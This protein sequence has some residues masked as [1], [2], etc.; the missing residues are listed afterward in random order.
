MRRSSS[1]INCLL[2]IDKPL[3]LSSHDVVGRVRRIL[4]ERRVGH[5]GTLDPAASGVLVIGVGQATRLLGMLTLDDKRYDA[6]IA[7]GCETA[8]DDAEGEVVREAEVPARLAEPAVAGA[9]VASLV[10][11]CEQ[12]PPA[13]SAISVDGRRAYDRARAGEEVVLPARHVVVHEATLVGVREGERLVWD[14]S[15]HVS[16]GTYIRSIARD[17]GRSMGTAAHLCA[18]RRTA[19]GPIGLDA[20]VTLEELEATGASDVM[21]HAIDPA[22]ALGLSTHEL[23]DYERDAAAVGR[24]FGCRKVVD[25]N[26]GERQPHEGEH[27]CLVR[28]GLLRGVWELRDGHMACVSNFPEGIGGVVR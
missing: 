8:T 13:Y 5:A 24:R 15:V 2:A 3:G 25:A 12:T 28:D 21:A 9:V 11:P 16:K 23:T 22:A 7:F 19:S 26:G 27:I 14:C 18:L 10:G 20:C 1:G 17:L 6:S 4:G